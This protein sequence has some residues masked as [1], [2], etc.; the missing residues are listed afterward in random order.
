MKSNKKASKA[1]RQ[2]EMLCEITKRITGVGP[3][4]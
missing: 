3:A 4:S 2:L 1:E